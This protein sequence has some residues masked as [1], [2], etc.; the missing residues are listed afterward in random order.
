MMA[1]TR[2]NEAYLPGISLPE[3]ITP[4]E[5]LETVIDQTH[6]L[7]LAIPSHAFRAV[8]KDPEAPPCI[9]ADQGQPV[10]GYQRI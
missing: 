7:V 8:L 4:V 6:E 2:A 10:L 3:N 5:H 9:D 1:Q